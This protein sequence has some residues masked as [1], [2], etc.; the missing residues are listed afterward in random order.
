ML[1]LRLNTIFCSCFVSHVG[2]FFGTFLGPVLALILCNTVVFVLVIR[3][4]IKHSIRKHEGTK[5]TKK[6]KGALKALISTMSIMFMFGL[7][8]LFGALTIAQ[9]SPIFQWLFVVFST[10]QGVFM[11][12]FV[13][14]MGKDSRRGWCSVF[15][16]GKKK[17]RPTVSH[18]KSNQNRNQNS[19]SNNFLTKSTSNRTES[20]NLMASDA[21]QLVSSSG[22]ST[23]KLS[24]LTPTLDSYEPAK[25]PAPTLNTIHINS[26]AE[27]TETEFVIVNGNVDGVDDNVH[28]ES[29]EIQK[30]DLSAPDADKHFEEGATGSDLQ[31]HMVC[32]GCGH[33]HLSQPTTSAQDTEIVHSTRRKTERYASAGVASQPPPRTAERRSMRYPKL[34]TA[35]DS[36][37]NRRKEKATMSRKDT[38]PKRKERL[39]SV[40][41]QVLLNSHT[42]D[43]CI[44]MNPPQ[45][46]QQKTRVS[47]VAANYYI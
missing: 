20:A 29:E 38:K 30:V 15:S 40:G 39:A 37:R 13:V 19:K 46:P 32:G 6:V 12:I 35:T 4:L 21:E 43:S 16:L 7:Q 22:D 8:W 26:I 1:L 25:K 9:A 18:S 41:S 33:H 24:S 2:V 5:N 34:T 14:V 45:V 28:S 47:D 11:F 23:V 10:L 36:H 42:E 44:D 17:L 27:E 31:P 3:V